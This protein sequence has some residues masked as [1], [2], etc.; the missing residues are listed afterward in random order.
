[1][2]DS[3]KSGEKSIRLYVVFIG[4]LN[5][6]YDVSSDADMPCGGIAGM[7]RRIGIVEDDEGLRLCLADAICRDADLQLAF[8]AGSVAEAVACIGAGKMDLCLVDLG[9]PDGSGLTVLDLLRAAGEVKCLIL[10][11][12]GDRQSVIAAL[13]AGA[14]GYLLKDT[15]PE[16]VCRNIKQA[17]ADETPISP[18]A[19]RYLL[20]LVRTDGAGTACAPEAA[21]LS[22]REIEVLKLFSR[23]LSYR[24]AAQTLAISAH[25]IGDHVKAIYRKLS[26]HSRA[27]AIFEARQMGL[28]GS[29]D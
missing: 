25:T 15:T 18:V 11:V 9:L 1:M 10:T 2:L 28:I 20:E 26:V 6:Q 23:G 16:Q 14:D 19:A 21:R 17:L 29:L 27:E 12:F 22:E 7:T 13:R 3:G 8:A 5:C 24:E 4:Y